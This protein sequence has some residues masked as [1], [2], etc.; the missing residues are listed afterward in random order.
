MRNL[1]IIGTQC[2]EPIDINVN[3]DT[4]STANAVINLDALG[5][6]DD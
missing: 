2:N 4:A 5:N 6:I 1:W 3:V